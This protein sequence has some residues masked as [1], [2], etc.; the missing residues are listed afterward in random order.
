MR[1]TILI[2]LGSLCVLFLGG[3]ATS[4]PKVPTV[5]ESTPLTPPKIVGS[6]GKLSGTQAKA[7]ISR[8]EQGAKAEEL[9]KKTAA[10]ME[11][12]G[13]ESRHPLMAGNKITLLVDGPATY[14]AM[15][16]TIEGAKDHINFETFIF[17]DDEVGRKFA[18]LLKKKQAEGVQVNLIYDAVGSFSTPV[19]FFQGL[20]DAGVNVL[21][22]NPINPMKMRRLRTTQRDHRKV[23]VV[24][25]KTGF[26]GGV[27]ISSVY[28]SSSSSSGGEPSKSKESWRD[29]H[30]QIEGPAVAE[31]QR[32]FI[33]TWRYQKAPPLADKN[34][35]PKLEAQGKAL[36]QV[37]SSFPGE[38][39]RFTYVMYV[40]AIKNAQ[41]SIDLTTPYFVPDHQMRKAIAEAAKRGVAVRIVL[42]S[43]SDSNLA[44]YAGRAYYS[45]LLESGVRL[46]EL[47]D[48]M[49]HAKT[50]VIDGVW[51]TVGST[52]MDLQSFLYNNEINVIVIG[53][54]FADGME[55]LFEQDLKESDEVTAEKW[56]QRPLLN[57]V[58][59]VFSRLL[60]PWL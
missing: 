23:A 11:T 34:Y 14:E 41:Y 10:L 40:A 5:T 12:V 55:E 56:S 44:L 50:A 53:K 54:D 31:L 15:F 3:C 29:T 1:Q 30:V 16:K 48:R 49:V 38:P 47:R 46:Y 43:S 26:I 37:I 58:K 6:K 18:D 28:S 35:F 2:F 22:F 45:D 8:E 36:A 7:V 24:D 17:N 39:H 57:R 13:G 32:S 21:E 52:N 20:R 9:I 4:L 19:D 25:G 33:Q 51:S 42:P 27:N 60:A 59:E